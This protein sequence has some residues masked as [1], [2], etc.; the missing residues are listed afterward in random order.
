MKP[1]PKKDEIEGILKD[2]LIRA[3]DATWL[4][5]QSFR[6]FRRMNHGFMIPIIL[7]S[8]VSGS[9]NLVVGSMGNATQCDDRVNYMQIAIGI[10]GMSTAAMTAI[11]NFLKVP[12]RVE[13]H[14]MFK[15]EFDRLARE[16]L[17]ES[18]LLETDAQNYVS[19]GVI[20]RKMQEE[21][22]RLGEKAPPIPNMIEKRLLKEKMKEP[23]LDIQVSDK[24]VNVLELSDLLVNQTYT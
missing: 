7:L 18:T 20:L 9:V 1:H 14:D 3:K 2:W 16:I 17:V 12:Q 24:R 8:T 22:D 23:N 4:H 6:W 15:N 19:I 5:L 11:Y 10:M 21:F 13:R